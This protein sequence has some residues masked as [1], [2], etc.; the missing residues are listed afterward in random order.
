MK[1]LA[2]VLWIVVIVVLVLIVKQEVIDKNKAT[3]V[4]GLKSASP[5]QVESTL[6]VKL[7]DSSAMAENVYEYSKA[8]SVTVKGDSANGI[9]VVYINGIQNGLRVENPQYIMFDIP[10]GKTRVGMESAMTYS[11]EEKFEIGE[12]VEKELF[13]DKTDF[14]VFYCNWTN[15]DCVVVSC[16][17]STGKVVA[18]TYFNNAKKVTERLVKK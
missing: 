12:D 7:S 8:G 9:G 6:N 4:T 13:G 10:I 14:P 16:E 15:N 1:H 11:Y 5:T 17:K 2:K 3:D 18:V